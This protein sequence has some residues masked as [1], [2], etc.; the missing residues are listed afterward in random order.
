MSTTILLENIAKAQAE[1][2]DKKPMMKDAKMRQRYHF[3]GEQGWINDPNGL[4]FFRGRYHFFYQVNPFDSYWGTIYWGH[5]VSDD[6]LHWEYL[7]IALAPSEPYD[8]C[9][10]GGCFSGTAIEWENRLYLVYTGTTKI[11]EQFIQRQCLAWSDDGIHFEKYEGNPILTTPPGVTMHNFRDPKVW[12]H[13]DWFYLACGAEKNKRAQ[14]L[15]YRS[16][17]LKDWEFVNVMFESRGEYGYMFE[18]PDF[19]QLGGMDILTLSPMGAGDR[20][21]VYLVG[22]MDYGTGKFYTVHSGEIDW[23]LDYYAPQSFQDAN[24]RRIMIAWG[25]AWDWMPWWRDWG[26]TYKEGW[27]GFYC[28]P[29][30]VRL[31]PDYSLQFLPVEELKQN[32][33]GEQ[34]RYGVEL[35]KEMLLDAGDGV[36]CEMKLIIDLEKTT[37]SSVQFLL[38]KNEERAALL[39]FDL[40]KGEMALDRNQADGWSCGVARSNLL[41]DGKTE[42]DIHI[43]LDQSSIEVFSCQYQMNMSCNVF[44]DNSQNINLV[45]ALDGKVYFKSIFTCGMKKT[46][47]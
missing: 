31:L 29:R 7:P 38:R 5:A 35:E 24:G 17:N 2:L 32:R 10:R 28:I 13:G 15:L 33:Y 40:K 44:A 36:A 25:N 3:M 26:P 9:D 12:R 42:L 39:T 4:I 27:C 21:V 47:D 18:C 1:I 22:R 30:E 20:T 16:V 45:Q 11:G 34:T 8:Y 19:F 37:A 14:L 6:L 41:L 43:F 23:G 46:M